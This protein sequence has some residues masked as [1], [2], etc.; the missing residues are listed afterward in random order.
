MT[1]YNGFIRKIKPSTDPRDIYTNAKR[2]L[3]NK[4]LLNIDLDDFFH[5]IDLQK[6][7]NL[8][9]DYSLFS[10]NSET[11]QLLVRLVSYRGRLPMGSPTSPPL[12]NFATIGI[13]NDLLAWAGKSHFDYT[14][15]VDDLSFSSNMKITQTHL[16]QIIEILFTHRFIIDP[17][18][19]KNFG[20]A[21][22][23]EVT[24]LMLGKT[25]GVGVMQDMYT[26]KN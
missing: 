14:R 21:D 2:H 1:G 26:A 22:V 10:F 3:G 16:D 18:K 9:S 19:T 8:F 25:I 12:S 23:K 15:F 20:L 24:G 5:Q 6:L 7:E 4:Y 11:E 13:D 17:A